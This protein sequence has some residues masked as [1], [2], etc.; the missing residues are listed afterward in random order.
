MFVLVIGCDGINSRVRQFVAG[1]DNPAARAGYAH[2]SAFRCLVD[3]E[4]AVSVLGHLAVTGSMFV[5]GML[6]S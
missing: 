6:A 4:S 3:Y 2:E 5:D 1:H